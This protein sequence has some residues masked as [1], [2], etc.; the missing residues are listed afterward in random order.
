MKG[1]FFTEQETLDYGR[2]AFKVLK[3]EHYRIYKVQ[4][5][6]KADN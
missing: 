6:V 5:T 1:D 3:V 4:V 2:F